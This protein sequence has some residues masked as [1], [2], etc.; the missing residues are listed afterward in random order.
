M[1]LHRQNPA[2]ASCHQRMDPL[3]FALENFDAVG[4]WRT[5]SDGAPVDPSAAFPDGTR[6]EGI[7]GLRT[8]MAAHQDDFVRTLSGKLLAFAVGRGLDYHD[9]PA[10]RRIAR[11]AAP[12]Y[13]WSALVTAIVRS[14]P[15]AMAA[16]SGDT[17]KTSAAPAGKAPR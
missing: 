7:G 12:T 11:E 10:I 13:S 3:G 8:L 5:A 1:E 14:T 15:F 2:C 16:A 9:Q 4:K 6:F 17:V